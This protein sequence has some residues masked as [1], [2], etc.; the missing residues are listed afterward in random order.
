MEARRRYQ[1]GNI[2][3][4]VAALGH[5]IGT[6]PLGATVAL[7]VAGGAIAFVAEAVV[8]GFGLL[9]HGLEPKILGV[10]ITVVLV[11]PAIVYLCLRLALLVVPPGLGATALAALIGT[12]FD[13]VTEPYGLA[14]G[15]WHYPEHPLS[16]PRIAGMPWWNAV[17]W[18]CLVCVSAAVPILVAL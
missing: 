12:G 17:G 4:F 13:L 6:W 2:G 15:V 18:F 8:V 14:E 10:P 9:D 7:F 3:I 11:W 1:L 16:R 5:A